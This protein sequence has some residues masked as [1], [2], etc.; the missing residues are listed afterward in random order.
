MSSADPPSARAL[1]AFGADTDAL[2]RLSGGRGLTWR[3]G[4]MVLRPSAGDGETAWKA[5]LLS[6]LAHTD[7]FRTPRP[8]RSRSGEW[9]VDR[10]EAWQWLPG[11]TDESRVADVRAA[12]TAFH[13]A[14]A[15]LDRPAFLDTAQDAWARADRIAWEE[16]PI[17]ADDTLHRLADA[18]E[19]VRARSQLVHG[20]LL[21]NVMFASGQ[22]PTIIDWAPYWRPTGYADAIVIA[23]AACWH[24][25]SLARL[26]DLV[27]GIPDGRQHLVRA[28]TFRI[29]TFILNGLWDHRMRDR[30]AGVV[31]AALR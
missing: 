11:A 15:D 9:T 30:H 2:E 31:E 7:G 25:L 22:A 19:P 8:I 13:A 14:V 1:R 10:W 21:G 5:E 17:P 12:G 20:D 18:F 29:S 24:G 3:T 26:H 6:V 27:A 23:D 4:A 16:E 28:L